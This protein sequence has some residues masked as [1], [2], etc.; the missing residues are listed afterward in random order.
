MTSADEA[1]ANGYAV[2][3]VHNR[4]AEPLNVVIE[5]WASGIILT[6][7]ASCEVWLRHDTFFGSDI[8]YAENYIAFYAE[9]AAIWQDGKMTLDLL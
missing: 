2:I 4:S 3:P 7:G 5:P 1:R 8:D 6:P 9:S